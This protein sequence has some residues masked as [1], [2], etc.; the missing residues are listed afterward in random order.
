MKKLMKTKGIKCPYH[1][2][3]FGKELDKS[4]TPAKEKEY[5]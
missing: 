2:I 1:F 5:P 3:F 4:I